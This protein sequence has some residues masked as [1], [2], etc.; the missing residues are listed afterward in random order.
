VAKNGRRGR[1]SFPGGSTTLTACAPAVF[2]PL[3][4]TLNRGRRVPARRG[5]P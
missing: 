5:A 4:K 2:R 3:G 1:V